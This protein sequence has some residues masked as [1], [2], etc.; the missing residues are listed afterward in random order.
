MFCHD[1]GAAHIAVAAA[2]EITR[3]VEAVHDAR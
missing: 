2:P 1:A 3:T